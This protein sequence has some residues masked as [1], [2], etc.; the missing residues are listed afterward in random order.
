[1][2]CS[3]RGHKESDSTERLTLACLSSVSA[4]GV[5]LCAFRGHGGS[6]W[7]EAGQVLGRWPPGR[8]AISPLLVI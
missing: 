6:L 8:G 3:P 1:M 2:G 7:D 4:T 5:P